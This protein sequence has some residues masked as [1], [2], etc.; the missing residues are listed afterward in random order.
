[1]TSTGEAAEADVAY[2]DAG[3]TL[4]QAGH[5]MRELGVAALRVRGKNG[6]VQGTISRDMVV[7]RI[8]AGGDPKTVT[9]G[10]VAALPP[11]I[12]ARSND[13]G[14]RHGDQ[15]QD[16]GDDQ[17]HWE[18]AGPDRGWHW[19]A[20]DSPDGTVAGD[21]AERRLPGLVALPVTV[22]GMVIPAPLP[23]PHDP[24]T[25]AGTAAAA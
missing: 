18:G 22:A 6:K 13:S 25:W 8:A 11:Y 19:A 14:A 23:S 4:R 10:E 15:G 7:R 24:L 21:G 1:V 20:P 5:L 2:I 17:T 16:P 12:P 9:V 3:K